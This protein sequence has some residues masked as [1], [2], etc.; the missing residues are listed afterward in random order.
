[1]AGRQAPGPGDAPRVRT[2]RYAFNLLR[3]GGLVATL[4]AGALAAGLAVRAASNY[5]RPA[6]VLP[7]ATPASVGMDYET[8]RLRTEDGVSI[9]AWYT[10]SR[11]GAALVMVHGIGAN[12]AELL[13]IARDLTERGYGLLL[14]DLRGHGES[15]DA[16]TTLGLNEIHDIRAAVRYL[17]GRPDVDAARIGCYGVSLG[18]AAVI[19]AAAEID[20]VRAVVVESP[21]ASAEW[22]A[23]NQFRK[24]V[25]LPH[26]FAPVV[27]RIGAWQAGVDPTL[28]APV[29][30]IG[31]ISPRP[32][33]LIH[34]AEDALFDEENFHLLAAAAREPKETWLVPGAGHVGA[35]I[36]HGAAYVERV[37]GFFDRALLGVARSGPLGSR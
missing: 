34:G 21:F 3:F 17:E 28:I 9:A 35:H 18:A 14:L 33:L 32:I 8:V 37:A 36:L 24:V 2:A 23:R 12:R 10:P 16:V 15:G 30:R 27:L 25:N 19:M 6:R 31:R 29:E 20:E 22:L 5:T 13:P 11:N 7:A 26:W 4:G 1:M